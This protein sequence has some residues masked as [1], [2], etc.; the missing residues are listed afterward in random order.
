MIDESYLPAE[1]D[2]GIVRGD[3]F[4]QAFSFT[5]DGDPVSLADGDARVQVR[6][7]AGDLLADFTLG[8]GLFFIDNTLYWTID[9]PDSV[10]YPV[11]RYRYDIELTLGGV[12]RTYV[13]G[14]FTVLKDITV[15]LS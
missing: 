4:S 14:Q 15:P 6:S 9:S 8:H 7:K 5:S 1:Y 11:G 3:T 2:T 10:E 12:K 13:A